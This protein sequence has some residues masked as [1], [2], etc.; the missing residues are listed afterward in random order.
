MLN[1]KFSQMLSTEVNSTACKLSA[2]D[3]V[4]VVD[5]AAC[6]WMRRA[7]LACPKRAPR[8]VAERL[9]TRSSFKFPHT[10]RTVSQGSFGVTA[11]QA[12]QGAV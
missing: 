5:I 2:V 6:R 9:D 10:P 3:E 4:S 8:V 1:T 7:G 12:S 11:P